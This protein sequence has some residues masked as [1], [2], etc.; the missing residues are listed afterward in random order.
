MER[1]P[2]HRKDG[3][4]KKPEKVPSRTDREMKHRNPKDDRHG[5]ASF[6]GPKGEPTI[7]DAE[8]ARGDRGLPEDRT[9]RGK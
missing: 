8:P 5:A 2:A 7:S 6:E 1:D 3:P 9:R 4:L